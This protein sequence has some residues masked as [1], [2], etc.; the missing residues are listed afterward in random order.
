ML[1]IVSKAV[2]VSDN[3]IGDNLDFA[4]V[5]LGNPHKSMLHLYFLVDHKKP[6][7]DVPHLKVCVTRVVR[8]EPTIVLMYQY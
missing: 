8:Y 4:V 5:F 3:R 6:Y 1:W 2:N 7:P